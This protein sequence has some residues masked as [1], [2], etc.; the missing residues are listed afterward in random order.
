MVI[1]EKALGTSHPD[2]ASTLQNLAVAVLRQGRYE[3]AEALV[4]TRRP[5]AGRRAEAGT[6]RRGG[7]SSVHAAH[8]CRGAFGQDG[9]T[10]SASEASCVVARVSEKSGNDHLGLLS[11]AGV[12]LAERSSQ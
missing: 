10:V 2:V 7:G 3:E 8:A 12:A 11:V 9:L 4:F 6:L 1:R 5:P